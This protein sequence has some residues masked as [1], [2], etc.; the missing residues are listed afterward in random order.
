MGLLPRLT[1]GGAEDPPRAATVSKSIRNCFTCKHD[2]MF[3]MYVVNVTVLGCSLLNK[4]VN[5]ST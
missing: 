3:A 1:A 4:T 5:S 2:S